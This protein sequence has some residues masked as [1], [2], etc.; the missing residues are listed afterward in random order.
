[1]QQTVIVTGGLGFIG[2]AIASK[3]R[4]QNYYVIGIGHG[5]F[6]VD[7][8]SK[9]IFHEWHKAS[10]SIENLKKIERKA[11]TIVHCAGGSTVGISLEQPYLDYHKTVNST[12]ELLEYIRINSPASKLI[13]LSSAAVYGSRDDEKIKEIDTPNPVS[14][15]GFHKLASENV[16]HSYAHCFNIDVTIIR[17]FSIYGR[18]L[19][20]Q[21]FW[22][23]ANKIMSASDNPVVFFGTGSETRDWLYIDDVT[24]LVSTSANQCRAGF[25]IYN[26]CSG[27][28]I[29]VKDIL[30]LLRKHLNRESVS[31]DF[32]QKV[33]PGDPLYYWGDTDKVKSIGW[34][35][36]TDVETGVKAYAE[37][38][39][40]KWYD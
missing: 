28:K 34:S 30:F 5:D 6:A 20:K 25:E 35:P 39:L 32:N 37:W 27:R 14:P 18:G 24:S 21:L 11:D 15:Y 3:F 29:S 10:L 23:A 31:I 9:G 12:L 4:S 7:A 22:D 13:Y 36:M 1:M 16:C 17:L 40:N 8:V 2:K 33:K 26:G 19:Q 38:F